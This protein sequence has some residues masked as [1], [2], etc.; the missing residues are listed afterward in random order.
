MEEKTK[1][2]MNFGKKV[3]KQ[4]LKKEFHSPTTWMASHSLLQKSRKEYN[5]PVF[6]KVK[7]AQKEKYV[8]IQNLRQVK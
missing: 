6:A 4:N 5:H 1:T 2:N 8:A 3:N 7:A